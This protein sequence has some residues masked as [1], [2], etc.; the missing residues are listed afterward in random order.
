MKKIFT[1][2]MMGILV[3]VVG[4]GKKDTS[5]GGGA[6]STAPSEVTLRFSWWGGDERHEKTLEAIKLFESKNPGI[7]IKGEYAGWG[8]Y[9]EKTMTQMAG[10]TA[11]DIMQINH[12]WLDA[13]SKDGKGYYDLNQVA[14]I[15]NLEANYDKEDLDK[16]TVNGKLNAVPVGMTAKEFYYNADTFAKAGIEIP[17]TWEEIF[18]AGKLFKEKLG[19]GYYVMQ[20]NAEYTFQTMLYYMEQ[21][22]GKPF[23]NNDKRINYTEEELLE[24]MKFYQKLVDENVLVPLPIKLSAGNVQLFEDPSWVDGKYAGVYEWDS[25]VE[26]Y[27]STL[28]DGQK[29]VAGDF[30]TL[31]G[32]VKEN[33]ALVKVS[34]TFGLN[35]NVKYPK[36]AAKFLDFMLN[37]PEAAKILG[38]SRG[39][40][41]SK[42]AQKVLEAEG[43]LKGLSYE[44]YQ[45]MQANKGFGLP[46]LVEHAQFKEL[47]N[48][49]FEEFGYNKITAEE[50]AKKILSEGNKILETITK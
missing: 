22:T 35:K 17:K 28:K 14:D 48:R 23:L 3:F 36:E 25:S 30:P 31:D 34:L 40:P 10:G 33:A 9:Y 37:D 8:G 27:Q 21:K 46:T 12:N 47:Y 24:G 2:L 20:A 38:L 42:S 41:S 32:G 50:A 5:T 15:L 7:K 19:T 44:G 39:I 43:M 11:A 4:C 29:L 13:F 18:E 26:K 1:L 16:T 45:K 6:S 49:V